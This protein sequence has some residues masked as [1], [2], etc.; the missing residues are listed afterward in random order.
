MMSPDSAVDYPAHP[1]YVN[2]LFSIAANLLVTDVF[3]ENQFTLPDY[4]VPPPGF[5]VSNASSESASTLPTADDLYSVAANILV[6]NAFLD[7]QLTSVEYEPDYSTPMILPEIKHTTNYCGYNEE[8]SPHTSPPPTCIMDEAIPE[9]FNS[10][11]PP[12]LSPHCNAFFDS[13]IIPFDYSSSLPASPTSTNLS[14]S[15]SDCDILPT[16][17]SE[18][19]ETLSDTFTTDLHI[20]NGTKQQSKP[21]RRPVS[22]SPPCSPS[23]PTS[24]YPANKG[25]NSC[26][27]CGI[28]FN[29][30]SHLKAHIKIYHRPEFSL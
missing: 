4:S 5:S 25:I 26:K 20:T 9:Q 8:Y 18:C 6:N 16:L 23:S 22:I 15:S 12:L 27:L 13:E 29:K 3:M 24:D 1:R 10:M 2:N 11:S 17:S 30:F 14:W 21:L 28:A 19:I 7:N